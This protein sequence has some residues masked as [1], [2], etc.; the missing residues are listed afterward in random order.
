MSQKPPIG[1]SDFRELR[2]NGRLYIDKSG[3]IADVIKDPAQVILFPRPRRFGKTLNL[4]MLRYFLEMRYEDLSS[5]FENLEIWRDTGAREHFQRHPTIFVTFKN[6]HAHSYSDTL[7]GVREV[8]RGVYEEHRYLLDTGSLSPEQEER[9]RKHL[10]SESTGE[11]IVCGALSELAGHLVRHH[12]ERVLVLIDEYD[13]PIQQGYFH[14]FYDEVVMLFRNLFSALLKDN[15]DVYKGVLTGI[16]RTSRESIFSGLNNLTVRSLLEPEYSTRFGFTENEV[17]EVVSRA[18]QRYLKEEL[19]DWY[20]G[21]CFGGEV[22]Y[23]PWSILSYAESGRFGSQW[24]NTSSDDLIRE[25]MLGQGL[26]LAGQIELLI[27]GGTIEKA[28]YE[29]I[30]LRDIDHNPDSLWSFLVFSGYLKATRLRPRGTELRADLAIPNRE[31]RGVYRGVFKTWLARSLGG[32]ERSRELREAI[33]SGEARVLEHRLND[34]IRVAF[35]YHD[36]AR[37]PETFYHGFVLALLVD[38]EETHDVRSNH[39]SGYGRADILVRPHTPGGPGAVLELKVA[40]GESS[41]QVERAA[42]Q[43]LQQLAER[44]YASELREAGAHP[45]HSL[46]VVCFGKRIWVRARARTGQVLVVNFHKKVI[47]IPGDL[48]GS[49]TLIVPA[50]E[51]P[52]LLPWKLGRDQW[53]EALQEI[54]RAVEEVARGDAT[55][56]AVLFQGPLPLAFALGRL[57]DEMISQPICYLYDE[58]GAR[59]IPAA[60]NGIAGNEPG[61]QLMPEIVDANKQGR[62]LLVALDGVRGINEISMKSLARELSCARALRLA[63][64]PG[65]RPVST[66]EEVRSVV[67]TVLGVLLELHE[68]TPGDLHIISRI[69]AAIAVTLGSELRPTRVGRVILYH[70]SAADNRH[71]PVLCFEQA[72]VHAVSAESNSRGGDEV[73]TK[74]GGGLA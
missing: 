66:A 27:R 62:G 61:P 1:Y 17:A 23:S 12:R 71:E 40:T 49:R 29:H 60:M 3:L 32:G 4:S 5:L 15:A 33:L 22:I 46:A 34:L 52:L 69:P 8:I 39:E 16:F 47:D 58:E 55:E 21:Y 57:L 74:G 68:E 63:A 43:A 41:V 2:E 24:V 6:V 18:G 7:E 38:L 26:S 72:G 59:W 65:A 35:S 54:R 9:F 42:Y 28:I 56:V 20:D 10:R 48:Q 64:L 53:S 45:I 70:Y 67:R 30:A 31:V 13:T 44:D 51:S 73:T 19:R 50:N 11:V 14:D 36:V 25:L 37:F